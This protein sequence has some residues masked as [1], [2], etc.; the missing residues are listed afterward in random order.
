M[1]LGHGMNDERDPIELSR[2]LVY[3][4]AERTL[5][6]WIRTALSLMALGFVIDRFGLVLQLLPGALR[7]AQTHPRAVW[8]WS[9]SIL[10]AMG[11]AMAL[12]AGGRY[13]RF[14]IA[15]HRE[16]TTRV[17]HGI[18]IG[19]VFSILL[20]LFGVALIVVLMAFLR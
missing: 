16:Q 12:G 6:S 7:R 19:A 10:V 9:G 13:L 3:L 4:A 18:V 17:R 20:G 8:A 15:Y 11:T 5:T 14:A 2:R 1:G